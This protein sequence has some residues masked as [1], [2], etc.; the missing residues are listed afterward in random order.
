MDLNFKKEKLNDLNLDEYL[1]KTYEI[2]K[3]T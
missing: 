3:E 1:I 2:K